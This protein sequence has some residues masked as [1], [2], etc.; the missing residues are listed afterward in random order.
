MD[1]KEKT[2]DENRKY[3]LQKVIS[4]SVELSEMERNLTEKKE[5]LINLIRMEK[6]ANSVLQSFSDGVKEGYSYF[7][8]NGMNISDEEKEYLKFLSDNG[9]KV[10][11]LKKDNV[12]IGYIVSIDDLL[13]N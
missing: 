11:S 5:N 13:N 6:K 12:V 3:I 4:T 9:A 10:T 7:T 1:E 8:V 2:R